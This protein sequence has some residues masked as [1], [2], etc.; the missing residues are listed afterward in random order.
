[1]PPQHAS[2]PVVAFFSVAA[3]LIV[4]LDEPGPCCDKQAAVTVLGLIVA[5][6][7]VAITF[8]FAVESYLR[9]GTA[10]AGARLRVIYPALAMAVVCASMSRV[11]G[12]VPGYAYGLIIG[13][14]QVKNRRED[15]RREAAGVARGAGIL[16]V[17]AVATWLLRQSGTA[18]AAAGDGTPFG[19][20]FIDTV[21]GLTTMMCLE[22]LVI[23]LVPLRFMS[24]SV[25]WRWSRAGWVAA[26][27]PGAALFVL[28]LIG[29]LPQGGTTLATVEHLI[30]MLWL[31]LGFGLGSF[32]FWGLFALRRTYPGT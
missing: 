3:A 5:I 29:P 24:G 23:G 25:L 19:L 22:T 9:R 18:E 32:L 8:E 20:R 21:L 2:G 16:L 10:A 26:Y 7:L 12:F 17:L 14:A 4:A 28:V 15:I 1:V 11:L 27:L 6:P 30:R 31:F 13:Y